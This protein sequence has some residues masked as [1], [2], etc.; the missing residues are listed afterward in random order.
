[1][2]LPFGIQRIKRE[3][4]FPDPES[5]GRRK[6]AA[7][8][9]QA[10]VSRLCRRAPRM[11]IFFRPISRV[12]LQQP[13]PLYTGNNQPSSPFYDSK[14]RGLRSEKGTMFLIWRHKS[15]RGGVEKSRRSASLLTLALLASS[16]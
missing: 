6:R 5:P 2:P 13:A 7:R 4:G 3:R 15:R 8:N 10:D 16:G 1:M 9:F 14:S 11:T 12:A